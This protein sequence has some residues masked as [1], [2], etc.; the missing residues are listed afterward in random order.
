MAWY[1]F[2]GAYTG[3]MTRGP[4]EFGFDPAGFCKVGRT[5]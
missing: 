3:E 5:S 4:G 2:T 1:L